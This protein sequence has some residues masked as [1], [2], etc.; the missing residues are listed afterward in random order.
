MVSISSFCGSDEST[1]LTSCSSALTSS[2]ATRASR[3]IRKSAAVAFSPSNLRS[4]FSVDT[5]SVRERLKSAPASAA[6]SSATPIHSWFSIAAV[7]AADAS[8]ACRNSDGIGSAGVAEAVCVT[9]PA[10]DPP[11][12]RAS[13][14]VMPVKPKAEKAL[15]TSFGSNVGN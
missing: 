10:A 2:A 4:A 6:E 13:L 7:S 8:P 9:A 3:K 12:M 11:A 15:T 14:E 1:G 5:Q